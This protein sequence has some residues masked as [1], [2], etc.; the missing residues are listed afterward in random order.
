MS[1]GLLRSQ[2]KDPVRPGRRVEIE[3]DVLPLSQVLPG[4]EAPVPHG[5]QRVTIHEADLPLVEAMVEKDMGKLAIATE[6]Y[7]TQ[8]REF[9]AIELR[10]DT[11]PLPIPED[12]SQWSDEMRSAEYRFTDSSPMKEFRRLTRHDMNALGSLR[13]VGEAPPEISR[14]AMLAADAVRYSGGF[15]QPS[16]LG[17]VLARIERLEAENASLR[18]SLGESTPRADK[19]APKS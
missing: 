19:R 11:G 12:R 6:M 14:E 9:L 3:V 5:L 15:A 4:V 1:D 7:E 2:R 17:D 18:A 10:T 16:N 8:L 13:V